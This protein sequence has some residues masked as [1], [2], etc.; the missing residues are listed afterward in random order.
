MDIA[1]VA[2]SAE[3]LANRRPSQE[4]KV[5]TLDAAAMLSPSQ[6]PPLPSISSSLSRSST[7]G[8]HLYK[9]PSVDDQSKSDSNLQVSVSDGKSGIEVLDFEQALKIGPPSP[10]R[11]DCASEKAVGDTTLPVPE[12]QAAKVRGDVKKPEIVLGL[13]SALAV[14]GNVGSGPASPRFQLPDPTVRTRGPGD[15][16]SLM[17]QKQPPENKPSGIQ[18][19][20]NALGLGWVVDKSGR[21]KTP[22]PTTV[23]NVPSAESINSPS[24]ILKPSSTESRRSDPAAP[25]RDLVDEAGRDGLHDGGGSSHGSRASSAWSFSTASRAGS[26]K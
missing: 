6:R 26:M 23:P 12:A 25:I 7:A 15:G 13:T 22:Q 19:L 10:P 8:Q 14:A 21:T 18:R 11:S 3:V 1:T 16:R 24:E 17:A 5:P 2:N 20:T 9:I 4:T